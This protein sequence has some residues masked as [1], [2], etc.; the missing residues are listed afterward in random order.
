MGATSFNTI[1]DSPNCSLL[2]TLTRRSSVPAKT[3][4][5]DVVVESS[6][7]FTISPVISLVPLPIA[8]NVIVA[9]VNSPVEPQPEDGARPQDPTTNTAFTGSF[10][11]HSKLLLQPLPCTQLASESTR[12]TVES[13]VMRIWNAVTSSEL[14][15]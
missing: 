11:V 5:S 8:V 1:G 9:T 12:S 15:P 3:I 2:A 7:I 14:D 13:N 4:V 10:V 6:L